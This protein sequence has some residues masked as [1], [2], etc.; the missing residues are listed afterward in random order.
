[1]PGTVP[2]DATDRRILELL[3][4]D[5]RRTIA[6]IA[7][8]VSLSPA[9]VK[10]R[11]DRLIK[12]GVITGFTV[13][14]DHTKIGQTIEAYTELRYAGAGDIDAIVSGISQLPEV[15][16]VCTIAGDPDALVRIRVDD[17][18]HLKRVVSK[19]RRNGQIVGTKTLIVLDR[20]SREHQAQIPL[21]FDTR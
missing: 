1:M 18:E 14:L 8:Q 9:P 13:Q 3:R 19:M 12:A 5:G 15:R 6:D 2:L 17:M 7:A 11:L 21:E 10:R 20:W 4:E 16:E